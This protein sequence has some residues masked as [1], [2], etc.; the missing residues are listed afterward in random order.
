M[1]DDDDALFDSIV[2]HAVPQM[3]YAAAKLGIADHL[4]GGPLDLV[5]L[6]ERTGA[7]P[8]SLARLLRALISLG[9]F[10]RTRKG[11]YRLERAGEPLLSQ[12][13]RSRRAAVL[14]AGEL[15]HRAWGSVMHAMQ[16]GES[17]FEHAFGHDMATHLANDEDAATTIEQMRSRRNAARNQALADVLP[18]SRVGTLADV[19]GGLGDLLVLLLTRHTHLRG[20]LIDLPAV[21]TRARA[22]AIG[23]ALGDRLEFVAA[24]ARTGELPRA[25]ASLVAELVHCMN[26]DAAVALLRRC[27][28]NTLYVVERVLEDG[29][30]ASMGHLADLHMLVMF[31]GR[32]R[33]RREFSQ[34]LDAAGWRL[35][36][37]LQTSSWVSV[38]VAARHSAG[39]HTA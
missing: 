20:V 22:Q 13:P 24:D 7:D 5:S 28:G 30:R 6:A 21:V 16:T 15:Q 33:T 38:V 10:V 18:L 12:H 23:G 1:T 37:V 29:G 8:D 11:T 25:D 36:R 31:G 4:R 32:E 39:L 19:G 34:L 9:L 17:A 14:Y 3:L 2:T 26:D 27:P 35:Q